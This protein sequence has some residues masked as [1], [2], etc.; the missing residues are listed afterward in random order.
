[1]L[2][3]VIGVVVDA[4]A[5]RIA[6]Q[7][8][9]RLLNLN[10]SG[11]QFVKVIA[12][13]GGVIPAV[14]YGISFG[15]GLADIHLIFLS[16]AIKISFAIGLIVLIVFLFLIIAEQVQDHYLARLYEKNRGRKLPLADGNYE[17]QYCGNRKVQEVDK[18][19]QV[20]GRDLQ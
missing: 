19:C 10:Q 14:L 5:C 6:G 9:P 11:I 8:M 3:G 20:C 13:F 17:C 15:L 1:L 2:N 7:A 4:L 12:L 16:S 18:T